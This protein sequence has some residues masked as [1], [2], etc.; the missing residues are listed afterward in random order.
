MELPNSN[1]INNLAGADLVF[2]NKLIEIIKGEHPLECEAY[3]GCIEASNF[4]EAAEAVHKLKNKISMLG[5]ELSYVLAQEHEEAL[6]NK[7]MSKHDSFLAI[8]QS[9]SHYIKKL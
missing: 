3:L 9:M 5:L 1:Y 6:K 4:N 8:L 2:K 7:D